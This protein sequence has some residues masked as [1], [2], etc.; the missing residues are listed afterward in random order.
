[1]E[2]DK[3]K[4][5]YWYYSYVQQAIGISVQSIQYAWEEPKISSQKLTFP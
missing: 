3:H 4:T 2:V 1:M 5:I